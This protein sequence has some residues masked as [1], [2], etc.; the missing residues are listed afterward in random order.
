MLRSPPDFVLGNQSEPSRKVLYG[1]LPIIRSRHRPSNSELGL[2]AYF[3]G[4]IQEGEQVTE[5]LL[6]IGLCL[7]AFSVVG[8][9]G[10][11]AEWIA[12]LL[13]CVSDLSK[14]KERKT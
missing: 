12:L 7:M 10:R 14:G 4:R 6:A 8:I 1:L 3:D 2:G 5:V 13:I 11:A 9:A